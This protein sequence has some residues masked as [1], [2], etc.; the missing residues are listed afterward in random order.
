MSLAHAMASYFDK[1]PLRGLARAGCLVAAGRAGFLAWGL[2]LASN[3]YAQAA[4]S[5]KPIIVD[6]SVP[7]QASKSAILDKLRTLYGNERVI[8]RIQVEA[9]PAPPNWGQYVAGMLTRDL[10]HVSTGKLEVEGQSVTISG[11]VSNEAQRQ[12]VASTLSLASNSSYTITNR[13]RLGDSAQGVLD[14]A[15]ANRIIE[16]QSGSAQLAPSGIAILDEM[17]AKLTQLGNV[18]VQ[19]IGHTDNVG[20]RASNL[21]L[22]Q[23]RAQAVR[24]YLANQGVDAARMSVLGKGP[25]APV[26][27]N[28]TVD[29]RARNRRIEFQVLQ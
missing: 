25:D 11:Q 20:Q 7:D 8:D 5:A 12:Q 13:L 27:D 16:F 6:G 15:L 9:I 1:L 10:Q 24:A 17:A 26:A 4:S 2:V 21:A 29:G 18:R 28:A 23:A 14:D 22:S 3:A 19:I